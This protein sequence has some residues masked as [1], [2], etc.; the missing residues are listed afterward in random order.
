ML[1]DMGVAGLR[2][3]ARTQKDRNHLQ[4]LPAAVTD[5]T[6]GGR[7]RKV[8]RR[9]LSENVHELLLQPGRRRAG[10]TIGEAIMTL[11]QRLTD[12]LQRLHRSSWSA[13]A[14][15]KSYDERSPSPV[16]L[17]HSP[18]ESLLRARHHLQLGPLGLR[19]S[20]RYGLLRLAFLAAVC[21]QDWRH[22]L[23]PKHW[24]C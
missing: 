23:H 7:H 19:S 21:C 6:P 20:G 15:N 13:Q 24:R 9:N 8:I 17:L 4:L 22:H 2:S 10:S 12:H 11:T 5:R 16:L 18:S 14:R 1:V 3:A